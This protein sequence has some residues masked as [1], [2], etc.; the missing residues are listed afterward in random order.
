MSDT[1]AYPKC[2]YVSSGERCAEDAMYDGLCGIHV[3]TVEETIELQREILSLLVEFKGVDSEE[4]VAAEIMNRI[5]GRVLDN[6][7]KEA[8]TQQKTLNMQGKTQRKYAREALVN[9]ALLRKQVEREDHLREDFGLLAKDLRVIEKK[10][11]LAPTSHVLSLALQEITS[12][13]ATAE[14]LADKELSDKLN[15]VRSAPI[16]DFGPVDRPEGLS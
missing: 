13:R 1:K 16:E 2:I 3:S 14:I 11:G 6:H 15:E 12:W 9:R 7:A 10:L 8:I 4:I 5:I